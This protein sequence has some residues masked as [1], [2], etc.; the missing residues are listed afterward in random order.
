MEGI[1]E[2]IEE[3]DKKKEE[4]QGAEGIVGVNMG[5]KDSCDHKENEGKE[6]GSEEK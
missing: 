6:E 2:S 3:S 5:E 1:E 4:E